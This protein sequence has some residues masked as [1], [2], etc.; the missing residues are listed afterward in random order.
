MDNKKISDTPFF[1]AELP[2]PPSVNN[3]W[4]KRVAG[5]G[6]KFVQVYLTSAAKEFRARVVRK[7]KIKGRREPFTGRLA[8]EVMIHPKNRR[9]TDIDNYQKGLWDALTHAEVYLDD[10][11]M[12]KLIAERGEVIKEG[13]VKVKLY[14]I[15]SDD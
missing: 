7:I 13:L 15:L 5:K 9:V 12:D 8:A 11:Q 6:R 2:L 4:G 10:S 3:Y 1:E 14:E